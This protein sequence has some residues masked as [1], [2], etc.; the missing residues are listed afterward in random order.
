MTAEYTAEAL[1]ELTANIENIEVRRTRNG[2]LQVQL[3]FAD[4]RLW[5][6]H[7]LHLDTIYQA[8]KVL[9]DAGYEGVSV[10]LSRPNRDGKGYIYSP[11]I[12]VNGPTQGQNAGAEVASLK[13]QIG[14]LQAMVSQ[15]IGAIPKGSEASTP[16]TEEDI[17]A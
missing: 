4:N 8:R 16:A 15:L 9:R 2:S 3:A 11:S 1:T 17:P 12:W 6:E 7:D 14:T 13:N 5:A 10:S